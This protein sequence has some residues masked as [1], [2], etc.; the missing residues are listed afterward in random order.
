[1]K[2]LIVAFRNLANAHIRSPLD[3]TL[4]NFLICKANKKYFVNV[5]KVLW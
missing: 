4:E 5:V 2:K 3:Q 1:M